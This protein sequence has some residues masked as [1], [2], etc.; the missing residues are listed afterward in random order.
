LQGAALEEVLAFFPAILA[1]QAHDAAFDTLL[2][3]L[4]AAGDAPETGKA[5]QHNVAQCIARLTMAA[6][7][8][9]ITLVVKGLLA[10]L[11]VLCRQPNLSCR[12]Q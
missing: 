4:L 11:Q 3:S 12:W 8:S 2:T 1:S 6:G 9:Q 10:Q 5:A 7:P